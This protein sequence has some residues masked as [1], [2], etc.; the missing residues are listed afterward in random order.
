MIPESEKATP[1]S[2][3]LFPSQRKIVEDFATAE[4]RSMS[5][6][7]QVII[8]DWKRMHEAIADGRMVLLAIRPEDRQPISNQ[9]GL[10]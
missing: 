4:R 8:E 1:T 9:I 7:I 10:Q 2:V 6:A 3:T 5:N